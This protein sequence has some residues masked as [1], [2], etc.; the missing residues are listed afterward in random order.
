MYLIFAKLKSISCSFSGLV[1]FVTTH[2]F[3]AYCLNFTRLR[4]VKYGL[5]RT[6]KVC[7][8][9]ILSIIL[10]SVQVI[11]CTIHSEF[12]FSLG[13]ADMMQ[14]VNKTNFLEKF[15]YAK[16]LRENDGAT[17]NEMYGDWMSLSR[18]SIAWKMIAFEIINE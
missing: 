17:S 7:S 5:I 13:H 14:N 12:Q 3:G 8:N 11:I 6:S 16:S 18:Q 1:T 4:L 2:P 10:S 15:C 9:S